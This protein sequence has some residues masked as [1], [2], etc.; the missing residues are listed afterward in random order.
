MLHF[1]VVGYSVLVPVQNS[2]T[3]FLMKLMSATQIAGFN[4]KHLNK[5]IQR[6]ANLKHAKE[7][8]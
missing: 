1:T 2:I 4:L 8:C 5:V 6:Q 7:W 3:V